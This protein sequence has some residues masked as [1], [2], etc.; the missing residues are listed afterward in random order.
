M[1]EEDFRAD[2]Y[3]SECFGILEDAGLNP[4]LYETPLWA[5]LSKEGG[6]SA[7]EAV[8][9]ILFEAFNIDFEILEWLGL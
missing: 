1:N 4:D 5:E 7:P 2:T 9:L 8:R 6:P 3:R